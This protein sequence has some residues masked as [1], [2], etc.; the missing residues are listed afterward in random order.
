MII[1]KKGLQTIKIKRGNI[2]NK[3]RGDTLQK[4]CKEK[5]KN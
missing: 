2:S 5:I 3:K 4:E 1:A